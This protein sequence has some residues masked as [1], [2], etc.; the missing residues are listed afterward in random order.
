[1]L[2]KRILTVIL[3]LIIILSVNITIFAELN[4]QSN[5]YAYGVKSAATGNDDSYLIAE[6]EWWKSIYVTSLGAGHN[7]DPNNPNLRVSRDMMSGYDTVSEGQAYGMLLALYFNDYDTFL[8]LYYYAWNHF[9]PDT[10]L[11]HWKVRCDSVNI[12]EF[13]LPIPHGIPYVQRTSLR[14]DIKPSW[15]IVIKYTDDPPNTSDYSQASQ[16]ERGYSSAADADLDMAGALVFA[17]YKWNSTYCRTQAAKMIRNIFDYCTEHVPHDNYCFLKNGTKWGGESTWNPSYFTPAWFRVFKQFI[18]DTQADT[19]SIFSQGKYNGEG[20]TTNED[21]SKACDDIINTMYEHMEKINAE[22]G[23]NGFFP[24]WCDTSGNYVQKAE[25]SDRK[26]YLEVFD[27][28]HGTAYYTS[29]YGKMSFNSY[30]DAVRVPWRLAMDYNWYGNTD[31]QNML[32]ETGIFFMNKFMGGAESNM[33]DGYSWYNGGEWKWDNRDGFNYSTGGEYPSLTF[34]SMNALSTMSNPAVGWQNYSTNWYEYL[35]TYPKDTVNPGD[36]NFFGFHYYSNTLRLISLLY[37]AG[38]FINYS[39]M[40]NP[41]SPVPSKNVIILQN[42]D[43][44]KRN[45]TITDELIFQIT[46]GSSGVI[47]IDSVN[48]YPSQVQVSING[49]PFQPTPQ[50]WGGPFYVAANSAVIFKVK[51]LVPTNIVLNWW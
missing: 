47:Q 48:P 49:G 17:W 51:A 27:H 44:D 20:S 22:N 16:Y 14:T 23:S 29:V 11:M 1:M 7:G 13:E 33:V 19:A 35:K 4:L 12:S 3:C 26:Y 24:D 15:D 50:Q 39:E 21:Y 30:Y 40:T 8:K 9:D 6:Y 37:L 45:Y 42:R 25:G 32:R 46:T 28:G 34:K 18:L 10:G 31:A 5:P 41:P 2:K 43:T 36:P 38:K